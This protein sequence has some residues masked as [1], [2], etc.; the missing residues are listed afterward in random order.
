MSCPE[1]YYEAEEKF[2][3]NVPYWE[4][5]M[6][7]LEKEYPNLHK[8]IINLWENHIAEMATDIMCVK[9]DRLYR[10]WKDSDNP[11]PIIFFNQKLSGKELVDLHKRGLFGKKE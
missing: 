9:G 3:E 1:E 6:A 11:K 4:E 7:S 5:V 8:K 2:S 10:S